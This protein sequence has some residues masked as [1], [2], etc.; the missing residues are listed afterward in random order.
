MLGSNL[1]QSFGVI[2]EEARSPMLEELEREEKDDKTK[3][4]EEDTLAWE[5]S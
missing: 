1:F 2:T 4:N 3:L 5:A